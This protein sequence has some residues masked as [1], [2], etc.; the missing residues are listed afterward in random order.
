GWHRALNAVV[1]MRRA[2][3]QSTEAPCR[4]GCR[5]V[6]ASDGLNRDQRFTRRDPVKTCIAALVFLG[7]AACATTGSVDPRLE[8]TYNSSVT[9]VV[10]VP[11]ATASDDVSNSLNLSATLAHTS[12]PLRPPSLP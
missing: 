1:A 6:R 3:P 7:A 11:Q 5:E 9:G 10:V 12:P 4:T 8:Y 2:Q